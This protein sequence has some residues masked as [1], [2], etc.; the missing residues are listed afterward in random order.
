MNQTRMTPI[1]IKDG[2]LYSFKEGTKLPEMASIQHAGK[3]E[4]LALPIEE[5][6]VERVLDLSYR[7]WS[8]SKRSK[9]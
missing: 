1:L 2:K 4:S 3:L 9:R 5:G 8:R 6:S 7:G